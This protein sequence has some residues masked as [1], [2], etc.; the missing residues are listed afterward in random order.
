MERFNGIPMEVF[1]LLC[2]QLYFVSRWEKGTTVGVAKDAAGVIKYN[3]NLHFYNQTFMPS[4]R[5]KVGMDMN[6]P[7]KVNIKKW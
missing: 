4:R 3:L 5:G 2:S 1:R 6:R 7:M